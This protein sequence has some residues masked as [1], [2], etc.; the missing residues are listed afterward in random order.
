M[1]HISCGVKTLSRL[2]RPDLTGCALVVANDFTV[3]SMGNENL[4]TPRITHCF[5]GQNRFSL[6]G[7]CCTPDLAAHLYRVPNMLASVNLLS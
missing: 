3:P 7:G 2:R 4:T 1:L 6:F 5:A